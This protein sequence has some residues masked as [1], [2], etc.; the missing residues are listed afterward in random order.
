MFSGCDST[1][2]RGLTMPTPA[3]TPP[4]IIR[5][6]ASAMPMWNARSEASV[7]MSATNVAS[8]RGRPVVSAAPRGFCLASATTLS[9]SGL[10]LAPATSSSIV[11]LKLP[12]ITAPRIAIASSP[13]TRETP[14]LMP[15]AIPT[16]RSSTEL[17]A[18]AVSGATVAESPRPKS[19]IPG[20]TPVT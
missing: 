9:A 15:D 6:P 18:V 17:S 16:C 3:T 20:S 7:T 11:D 4:M 8:S 5:P 13:A 12:A 10:R 14:L 19:T 2:S 1:G